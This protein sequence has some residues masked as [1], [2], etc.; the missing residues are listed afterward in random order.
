MSP[1]HQTASTPSAST[2]ART[3]SSACRLACTSVITATRIARAA[4][5]AAAVALWVFAATRLWRT[6]VPSDLHVPRLNETRLFGAGL[7]HEARRVERFFDWAWVLSTLL[8][9][10]AYALVFRRARVIAPR[11]GLGR[12]NAGIVLGVVAL[13]AAWA[14]A[15]GG[16]PARHRRHLPRCRLPRGSVGRGAS[17]RPRGDVVAPPSRRLARVVRRRGR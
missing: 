12:G 7:V 4:T 16:A 11:L 17:G 3:A 10:A 5:I 15:A 1:R 2:A 9:F 13:G 8:V 6:T 14:G